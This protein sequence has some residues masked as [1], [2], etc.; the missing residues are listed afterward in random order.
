MELPTLFRT[1]PN[2]P[3]LGHATSERTGGVSVGPFESL[4]I[5]L[6]VGDQPEAVLENRR[7][8]S[9][10]LGRP[11]EQWVLAEQVHGARVQVVGAADAGQGSTRQ[12][13]R[14]PRCDAL[15][16]TSDQV[17]LVVLTA[18]CVPLVM[19]DPVRHAVAV[20][21]AGWRG[22]RAGIAAAC[23]TSLAREFGCRAANLHVGLGPSIGPEDYEVGT[24][25]A[26][27][28]DAAVVHGTYLDLW[29][30]NRR[31]LTEAGVRDK[32]IATAGISTYAYEERF[33]S[34]RRQTQRSPQT[35]SGIFATAAWLTNR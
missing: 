2:L 22:T 20:A 34:H 18:D 23:V 1:L 28:F 15:I 8:L 10:A 4:N 27:Q 7:R 21:H 29:T 9:S 5:S 31:Q 13:D 25:V 35:Q 24:Q 12:E 16:T 11:L 19:Y 17:T 30:A 14:I 32:N 3:G 33:F 6:G 26:A